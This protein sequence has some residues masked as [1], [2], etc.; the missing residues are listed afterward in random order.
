MFRVHLAKKEENKDQ[1]S[2]FSKMIYLTYINCYLFVSAD[3]IRENGLQAGDFIVLYSD[4]K[5]GKYVCLH[6][7]LYIST[8]IHTHFVVMKPF[9]ELNS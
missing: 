9:D 1:G 5:S 6:S 2:G 7:S 4:V 3:F 8:Y